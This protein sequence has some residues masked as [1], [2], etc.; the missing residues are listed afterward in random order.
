VVCVRT[1]HGRVSP[2][3][4]AHL[5]R[6][7]LN[8]ENHVLAHGRG[9]VP[10]NERMLRSAWLHPRSTRAIWNE[11]GMQP[12]STSC[13]S[14]RLVPTKFF[15]PWRDRAGADAGPNRKGLCRGDDEGSCGLV[16]RVGMHHVLPGVCQPIDLAPHLA[17]CS[18]RKRQAFPPPC[19][20][21]SWGVFINKGEAGS[22]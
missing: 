9:D 4:L 21:R 11:A 8:G 19:W 3:A 5:P 22:A 2:H 10:A 13:P 1:S 20:P 17:E 7:G 16:L 6:L 18:D 12:F 15:C 14:D